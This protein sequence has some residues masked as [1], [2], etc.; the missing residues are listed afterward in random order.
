MFLSFIIFERGMVKI[1]SAGSIEVA[2]DVVHLIKGEVLFIV[3]L[4][5]L[6]VCISSHICET[7]F[8]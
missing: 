4:K 5:H 8:N 6:M 2:I 3:Y 1:R 7:P